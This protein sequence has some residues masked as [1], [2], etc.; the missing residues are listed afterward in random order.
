MGYCAV[1]VILYCLRGADSSRVNMHAVFV[2]ERITN[3]QC[4]NKLWIWSVLLREK[5]L[6]ILALGKYSYF[7][8]S[9]LK[10]LACLYLNPVPRVVPSDQNA[11]GWI[12]SVGIG[13]TVQQ[14]QGAG[15]TQ[16]TGQIYEKRRYSIYKHWAMSAHLHICSIFTAAAVTCHSMYL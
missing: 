2:C 15:P 5:D 16:S 9:L 8:P 13:D 7:H 4:K 1:L 12:H 14:R 11:A 6:C 10:Y 3:K